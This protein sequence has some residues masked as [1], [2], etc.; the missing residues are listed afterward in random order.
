VVHVD[1]V[2]TKV[3]F[4]ASEEIGKEH[5]PEF[6]LIALPL[7]VSLVF[8]VIFD[9]IKFSEFFGDDVLKDLAL[10]HY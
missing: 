7:I 1:F 5:R 6:I 10:V 8:S 3:E 2:E 9:F 4:A